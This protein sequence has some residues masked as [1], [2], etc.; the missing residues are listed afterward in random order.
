MSAL[1]P[2]KKPGAASVIK[3]K[4]SEKPLEGLLNHII[5][6]EKSMQIE[7]QSGETKRSYYFAKGKPVFCH[8][9]LQVLT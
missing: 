3:G 9:S 2:K 7:L 4:L 5:Q 8:S 6:N 1:K